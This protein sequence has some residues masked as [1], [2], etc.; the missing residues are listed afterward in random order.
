MADSSSLFPQHLGIDV[1]KVLIMCQGSVL[2]GSEIKRA[3]LIETE[4]HFSH[5]PIVLTQRGL[6]TSQNLSP[7]NIMD[8]NAIMSQSWYEVNRNN[9]QN[10]FRKL[11]RMC[12]G[13]GNA[14]SY[15]IKGNLF[16]AFL[17][18]SFFSP[19]RDCCLFILVFLTLAQQR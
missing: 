4:L 10:V 7:C 12:V 5:L 2:G 18:T 6:L 8:A 19:G 1:V 9:T 3:E 13:L 15:Y 17:A 14:S 16:F 11:L